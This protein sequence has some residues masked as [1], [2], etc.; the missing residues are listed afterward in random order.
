MTIAANHSD[1]G[2]IYDL[3]SFGPKDGKYRLWYFDN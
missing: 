2:N 1:P 3:R